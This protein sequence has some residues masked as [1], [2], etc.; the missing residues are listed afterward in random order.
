[1]FLLILQIVLF[2]LSMF[3]NKPDVQ[4]AKPASLGDFQLP[5]ASETRPVPILWG[6]RDIK[7]PNV[8]WYG[9]L[10][11]VKIVTKVRSGFKK[12]KVTVGF[13]YFLG[14]DLVLCYGLIDRVVRLE[15]SDRVATT[16]VIGPFGPTAVSYVINAPNLL[17]GKEKGGGVVGTFTVYGGHPTQAKD[18]YLIT[19]MAGGNPEN[20]P[21]YVD[22]AHAVA[23]RVEVGESPQ[24]GAYVFRVSRFPDNLGLTGSNHIVRG[25]VTDGDANPAEVIYEILTSKVFGLGLDSSTV[26]LASFVAAGDTLASEGIGI[27][28]VVDRIQ[29]AKEIIKQ[30]LDICNA[31]LYE[32]TDGTFVLKLIRDDYGSVASLELYDESNVVRVQ[33]FSRGSWSETHNHVNVKFADRTKDNIETGSMAQDLANFRTT[34]EENRIDINYPACGHPTTA[35]IAAERDLLQFSFP[36]A[37]VKLDVQRVG[38]KLRPGDVIRW[39][40]DKYGIQDMP[41]RIVE[42]QLG[43]LLNNVVTIRGVQDVFRIAETIY[44]DPPDTSW[45]PI[46]TDA[47]KFV[48]EIVRSLPRLIHNL[49]FAEDGS[50]DPALGQRIHSMAKTPNG[51]VATFEQWVDLGLGAGYEGDIG[52]A[53]A[54]T[55]AGTLQDDYLADTA[56]TDATGFV[57]ENFEGG[58]NLEDADASEVLTGVNLML[59]EGPTGDGSDDEIVAFETAVVVGSEVTFTNVHRGLLDTVPRDHLAGARVWVF[60]YGDAVSDTTYTETQDIDV[61]HQSQTP[62]SE[63]D[64][65]SADALNLVFPDRLR[66]PHHPV[67][68]TVNSTRVAEAVD[69]TAD[70]DFDWLHRTNDETT[71]QDDD[72]GSPNAQD[73]EVEYDLEFRHGVTSAILRTETL[74]SP[75][76]AWLTYL[77]T[78]ANLQSD[79]GQVGDFPLRVLMQSRYSGSAT[80]NPANLTSLQQ[81]SYRFNVDMGGSVLRSV[82]L[83]GTDEYIRTNQATRGFTDAH[84]QE[85]WIKWNTL[86]GGA[87]TIALVLGTGNGNRIELAV[88]AATASQPF[89]LRLWNSTG[90]VY[91][92]VDFGS[93]PSAGT[94]TQIAWTYDGGVTNDPLLVYQDG[95]NVTGSATFNTDTTGAQTNGSQRFIGGV[96]STLASGF[97]NVRLWRWGVWN[98][99]LGGAEI[100]ALYNGGSGSAVNPRFDFGNYAGMDEHMHMW[101]FRDTANPGQ[102]FGNDSPAVTGNLLDIFT[103]GQNVD[104]T[105]LVADTP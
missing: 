41:L 42:V 21:A 79:T 73:T 95:A 71:V 29:R 93:I 17:G 62:N 36:L 69:E 4:N 28:M 99:A 3:L 87:E 53:L 67:G 90:T 96:D 77:Y 72:T 16:G 30:I 97:A 24:I 2:I 45:T 32:E 83:N 84:T 23:N 102:D 59:I 64:I 40:W 60:S 20:V 63:L 66:R 14:M 92:D 11:I 52:T 78:Q 33:S 47:V 51:T 74:V 18:G 100:N 68:F 81:S 31:V 89:N 37:R 26:D 55:P 57:A 25:T 65:A 80:V 12:K 27:S 58:E 103:A 44:G 105:D 15:V 54:C 43:D 98:A 76:P 34:Q 46:D 13:R 50:L 91:K 61:K 101:D 48:D 104:A 85:I 38:A 82:D 6:T 19:R 86:G 75:A 56:S 39:S 8:I 1:M 94:W 22:I 35:R 7:G 9:D 10:R 70:L 49:S 88:G 5:T